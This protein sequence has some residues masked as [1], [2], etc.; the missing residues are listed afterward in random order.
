MLF[1]CPVHIM[2]MLFVTSILFVRQR[3]Q[4]SI[5]IVTL[6]LSCLFRKELDTPGYNTDNNLELLHNFICQIT[7]CIMVVYMNFWK[8]MYKFQGFN[9][10]YCLD[11]RLVL[12]SFQLT[13]LFGQRGGVILFIVKVCQKLQREAWYYQDISRVNIISSRAG[14]I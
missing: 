7:R 9:L 3:T 5:I 13:V 4:Q 2:D 11:F 12:V 14:I 1:Y 6:F 8:Y 10:K